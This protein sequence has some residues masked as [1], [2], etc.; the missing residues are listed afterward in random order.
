M[1]CRRP[2]LLQLRYGERTGWWS[3]S[4]AI[5]RLVVSRDLS[6]IN[7]K[8]TYAVLGV[9]DVAACQPPKATEFARAFGIFEYRVDVYFDTVFDSSMGDAAG[10]R[11]QE[12]SLS[13][14]L[15]VFLYSQGRRREACEYHI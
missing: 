1:A 12:A 6:R 11:G 15:G 14:T 2:V 8:E 10:R 9:P 4:G 7:R 3:S 5:D 13:A